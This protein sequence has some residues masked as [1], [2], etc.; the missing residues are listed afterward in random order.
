MLGLVDYQS[1][2]DAPSEADT[3]SQRPIAT[4]DPPAAVPSA[5][6]SA[7]GPQP[8]ALPDASALFA[9]GVDSRS[10]L[11]ITQTSLSGKL[12]HILTF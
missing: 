8:Q 10:G 1:D 7:T 6:T 9:A 5:D 12:M 4:V 11:S 2:D 3:G